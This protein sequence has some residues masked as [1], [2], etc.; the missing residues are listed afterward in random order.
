[1]RIHLLPSLLIAV[2]A[3]GALLQAGAQLFAV[4]VVVGTVTAAPPRSLA[5][6][7]GEYGYDSGSFW[8]VVPT[9]TLV[10]LFAA[11]VA[12]WKTPQRRL[13]ISAVGAFVIAGLFAGFVTGPLQAEIIS[14]G[15]A[16][17]VDPAL[18]AR[19]ARWRLLD[20]VSWGL[21]LVPGI[22]LMMSLVGQAT[23]HPGPMHPAANEVGSRLH[24]WRGVAVFF[25]LPW[26]WH[27]CF[28]RSVVP[29]VA[30]HFPLIG[31]VALLGGV[32][33]LGATRPW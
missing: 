11:L 9:I 15:F 19:A 2:A 18:T 3:I 33:T 21:T 20:W 5:M 25:A 26:R 8:E 6:Y 7:A 22:L 13:M 27:A 30:R 17:S 23:E 31:T 32:A 10:L 4:S 1:M 12:N 16:D 29:W 24:E 14:A 28:T